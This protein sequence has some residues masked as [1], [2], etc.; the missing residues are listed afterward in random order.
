MKRRLLLGR[1]LFGT[2]PGQ[3]AIDD[4]GDLFTTDVARRGTD[5]SGGWLLLTLRARASCEDGLRRLRARLLGSDGGARALDRACLERDA[6]DV[7]QVQRRDVVR[8]DVA[9]P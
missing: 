8:S 1:T 2:T 6:L 3:K 9:A 5:R 4:G 7:H